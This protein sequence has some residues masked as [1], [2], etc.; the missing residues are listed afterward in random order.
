MMQSARRTGHITDW[1]R[2]VCNEIINHDVIVAGRRRRSP[3][4]FV[5][6]VIAYYRNNIILLFSPFPRIGRRRCCVSCTWCDI[7]LY[8][9]LHRLHSAM[10]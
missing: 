5:I 9:I 7:I 1:F 6:I 8:L 4:F 3:L 10:R 2:F